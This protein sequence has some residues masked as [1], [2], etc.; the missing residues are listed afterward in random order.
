[1]SFIRVVYRSRVQ[2]LFTGNIKN[3]LLVGTP[4]KKMPHFPPEI[5][6]YL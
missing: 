1:M 3:T 2:R 6:T 4:L 5:I